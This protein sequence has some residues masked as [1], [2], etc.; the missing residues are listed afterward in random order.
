MAMTP[1]RPARLLLAI[2]C[3]FLLSEQTNATA[4]TVPAPAIYKIISIIVNPSGMAVVGR[5]TLTVTQLTPELQRRLWKSYL[6]TGKMYDALKV[7][8][9]GDV[10]EEVRKVVLESVHEAQQK[11]LMDYCLDKH[12]KR[13][14]NLSSGQQKKIRKQFPVLFQESLE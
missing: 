9:A 5:D 8:F 10:P 6:G 13:F 11:A 3:C 14:E 2:L 12:Q 1:V 4:H 7:I